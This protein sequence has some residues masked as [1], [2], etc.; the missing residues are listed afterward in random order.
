MRARLEAARAW[1]RHVKG[2]GFTSPQDAFGDEVAVDGHTQC[3]ADADI[4]QGLA[5][6]LV[7]GDGCIDADEGAG[8]V[9]VEPEERGLLLAELDDLVGR[10]GA[11]DVELTAA[12]GAFFGEEVGDGAELHAVQRDVSGVPIARILADDDAASDG[13]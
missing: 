2:G 6:G 10:H 11:S 8:E 9:R 5:D 3:P 1:G 12:E 13:P 4:G 7:A